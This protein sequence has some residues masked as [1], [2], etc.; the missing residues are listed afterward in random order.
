MLPRGLSYHQIILKYTNVTLAQMK[1]IR[2]EVN[3][4]SIPNIQ[5]RC[6]ELTLSTQYHRGLAEN[7]FIVLHFAR[8]E[9]DDLLQQRSSLR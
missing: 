4:K 6:V 1:N 9:L 2:M 3:G 8:P 5:R 7:G